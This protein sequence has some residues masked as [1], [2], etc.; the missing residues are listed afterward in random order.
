MYVHLHTFLA[1][2]TIMKHSLFILFTLCY[3][4]TFSQVGIGT[5]SPKA[6]LE[7]VGN[8]GSPA[9]LDGIIAPKLTGI[10]LRDKNYTTDQI[11][12]MIYVTQ[13]DTSPQGQTI[14]VTNPGYYQFNGLV[15]LTLGGVNAV[16]TSKFTNNTVGSR[17]ELTNLS[18]GTTS[19]SGTNQFVIEDNGDLGIG[20]N[21]PSEKLHV[22]GGGRIT[23]NLTI[24]NEPTSGTKLLVASNT[25][26]T[27][28]LGNSSTFNQV[29]SGRIIFEESVPE[30][31]N[32]AENVYCGFS[33]SHNGNSNKLMINSA[34][35]AHTS[36]ITFER[37]GDIGIGTDHPT[38][39]LSVNGTANKP[40]GGNWGS[41]SDARLKENISEYSE[42]LDL[43]MKV[44]PVNYSYNKEYSLIFGKNKK[45]EGKVYQGVIAQ[46]LQKIAPDMV[47]NIK[48]SKTK[49]NDIDYDKTVKRD[50]KAI[51]Y[52]KV[53]P[54]KF[55]YALINSVQ[56]QQKQILQ[57]QKEIDEL[58]SVVKKL[59]NK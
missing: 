55:T 56:T 5:T 36:I 30:F 9:T 35:T 38:A 52:L 15:W 27:I 7:V 25:N 32:S 33:I 6:T 20:V 18:N 46:D 12:T 47:S 59:L 19:R 54:S 4:V 53:D 58:K 49:S 13:A 42:G 41:F 50:N 24:G 14:N 23:S 45:I 37:D 26:P 21:N 44:K 16:T 1:P 10:Q 17:V 11:G 43:I 34:C 48:L 31:V 8:S 22:Q 29:S 2:I 39:K 40:G 28:M 3:T 57:Q 51:P